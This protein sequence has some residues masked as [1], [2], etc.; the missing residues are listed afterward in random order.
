V[1][2]HPELLSKIEFALSQLAEDAFHP[3]L[4]T[5]KLK[6]DL[7]GSWACT[8]DYEYR[9]VFE[10]AKDLETGEELILLEAIGTHD[11]VY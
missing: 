6:G 3:S 2:H 11:E 8:V 1:R 4:H 5:H 10:S 9:I 7:A